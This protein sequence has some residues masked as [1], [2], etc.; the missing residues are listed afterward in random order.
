MMYFSRW[1]AAAIL[2][3][4][5]LGLLLSIPNLVPRSALPSWLPAPQVSLGLDLRGGSY[6]LLEVDLAAAVRER[7]ESLVDAAR[8]ELRDA[9]VQYV[10][11]GSQAAE[12]RMSVR[13]RDP[14][15][16]RP[17]RGPSGNSPRRWLSATGPPGGR[18]SR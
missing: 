4:C 8:T 3:V 11:L 2:G 13:V 14:A 17:R 10:D 6:L 5:L 7:L 9:R 15:Q 12:R 1:K 16:P 18:T